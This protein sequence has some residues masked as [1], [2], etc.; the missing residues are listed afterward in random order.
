MASLR[1]LT[2]MDVIGAREGRA[3]SR[4]IVLHWQPVDDLAGAYTE[5]LAFHDAGERF[6]RARRF[7]EAVQTASAAVE[8]PF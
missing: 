2:R 1:V 8:E 4:Q 3:R 6:R 5:T 7:Y